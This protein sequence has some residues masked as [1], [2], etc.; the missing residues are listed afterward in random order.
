MTRLLATAALVMFVA[1]GTALAN[2]ATTG[3]PSTGA[4]Q[5]SAQ[6]ASNLPQEITQ[7]LKTD[8]YTN[9]EV[10]PGSYVVSAKDK[11]GNP[12]T[13]FIGPHSWTMVK[14]IDGSQAT[15]S[16]ASDDTAD[17]SADDNK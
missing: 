10:A 4:S 5:W 12:V 1:H 2:D 7:E 17:K 9:V 11:H 8:G 14:A 15:G 16:A 13:M 3:N 6:T